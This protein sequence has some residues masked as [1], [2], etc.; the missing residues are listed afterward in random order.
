MSITVLGIDLGKNGCSLAGL[1]EH[2]AVIKRWRMRRESI[3]KFTTALSP[4]VVA[5]EAYQSSRGEP[6]QNATQLHSEPLARSDD[7]EAPEKRG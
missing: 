5:V 7:A 3:A 4:C 6:L 1:D 2:G